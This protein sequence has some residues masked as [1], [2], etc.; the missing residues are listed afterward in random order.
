MIMRF[1]RCLLILVLLALPLAAGAH[2]G[3]DEAR[4]AEVDRIRQLNAQWVSALAEKNLDAIVQLY[5][6]DGRFMPPNAPGVKGHR[7]IRKAWKPI[8]E[9]PGV[10]LIF[11]PM[12]IEIAEG[13]DMASDVGTY[14][15]SFDGANGRREQ[16]GKYLVVWKKVAGEWKVAADIFNADQAAR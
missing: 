9:I 15:L 7:A 14:L 8:L 13:M 12:S 3:G 5:A 10:F 4:E 2:A 6:P 16:R 11:K 1:G